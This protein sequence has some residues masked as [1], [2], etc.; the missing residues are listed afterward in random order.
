MVYNQTFFPREVQRESSFQVV[1]NHGMDDWGS[2]LVELLCLLLSRGSPHSGDRLTGH[3]DRMPIV[4]PHIEWTGL[5]S[6]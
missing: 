6:R 1:G 3:L 4:F 2:Q 5:S